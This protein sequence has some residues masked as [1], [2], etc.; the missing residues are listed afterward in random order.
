MRRRIV[1]RRWQTTSRWRMSA[2]VASLSA[3][4]LLTLAA[5]APGYAAA[6]D[7]APLEAEPKISETHCTSVD[8]ETTNLNRDDCLHSSAA[9]SSALTSSHAGVSTHYA[10]YA[11]VAD[12]YIVALGRD[13]GTFTAVSTHYADYRAVADPKVVALGRDYGTFAV[14]STHYADYIA[15]AEPKVVPLGR[16]YGTFA[17]VSTHYADYVAVADPKVVPLDRE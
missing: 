15:V 8:A 11:A 16:D 3:L 17:A 7:I 12:P 13:Y 2:N 9:S 4:L 5:F 1:D 10:D 14:V 6:A